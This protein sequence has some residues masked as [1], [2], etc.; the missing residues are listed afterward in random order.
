MQNST[1]KAIQAS[2][3]SAALA[4]VKIAF[5]GSGFAQFK[6]TLS[7]ALQSQAWEAKSPLE[8][9]K[10]VG[11]SGL[12]RR[13]ENMQLKTE[14]SLSDAFQDIDSLMSKAGEMVKLSEVISGKLKAREQVTQEQDDAFKSVIASL[15][16]QSI[17][18]RYEQFLLTM[19][20]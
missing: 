3:Q 4:F 18:T 14:A 13:A 19:L 10:A 1:P 20:L 2:T 11:I 8:S 15:G 12:M 7:Q 9:E 17:V 16:V 5:K 6:A